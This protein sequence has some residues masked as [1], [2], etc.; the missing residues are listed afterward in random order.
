MAASVRRSLVSIFGLLAIAWAICAF[1]IF[2]DDSLPVDIAQ[3]ILS[4]EKFSVAQLIAMKAP[5]DAVLSGS[6][7]ASAL[8][9]A[10]VIRLLLFE[11][12]LN[13]GNSQTFDAEIAELKTIVSAVLA[14]SPTNSFIWLTDVWIQRLRG[15]V[16]GAN[17]KLLRMSYWSGPN[18][19]WIAVR[20]N[21][22]ALGLLSSS[23]DELAEQAFA[24]F[25]NLV[26]SGL[27]SNAADIIAGPG[28]AFH[29][30]LLGRLVQVREADRRA[31]AN[32]LEAKNL[33]VRVPGIEERPTRPF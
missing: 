26:A 3:R 16:T 30:K 15:E 2:R 31:F 1:L 7:E 9:S 11:R 13:A 21:P 24:E 33:D 14:R 29:E 6:P 23:P 27:Y 10:A 18:E 19:A 20:R 5:S 8:G 17:F 4:G 12:E 32:V 25:A 28:W 22:I